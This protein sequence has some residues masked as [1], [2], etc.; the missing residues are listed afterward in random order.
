[1][2]DYGGVSRCLLGRDNRPNGGDRTNGEDRSGGGDTGEG[3]DDGDDGLGGVVGGVLGGVLG[4]SALVPKTSST[5]AA[6]AP[7]PEATGPKNPLRYAGAY[8]DTT[9]GEGNYYLQARNYNPG[10]GRFTATDPMASSRLAISS[11][12]YA[13][14]NPLV[15][16]DPTGTMVAPDP[17]GVGPSTTTEPDPGPSPEET[18]N[19]GPSPEE[20][21]KAQQIQS[22]SVLDVVLEAGGQ[23]LMEVLGINDLLKCLNG[24]LGACVSTVIGALPWGKIFKAKKIAEAIFRAG[25]AVITF[26]KEVKWARAIISGAEDAA[27][28]AKAAAAR[29]AKAA[30]QRAAAARAAAQRAA[31]AAA[32]K[33]AARAKAL[34]SKA[35]KTGGSR[36]DDA[37]R[38][39]PD[40]AGGNSSAPSC[41][42]SVPKRNSFVASTTILLADGTRKPIEKVQPGDTVVATDT[43]S[44][45]T[46]KRQV[47]HTIRTD[48]DKGIVDLTVRTKDGRHT[49]TTTEHHPF[50]STTNNH[51]VDAG[52][53]EPGDRLRTSGGGYAQ[54]GAVREGGERQLE[55][56][57]HVASLLRGEV[58][59]LRRPDGSHTNW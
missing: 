11:Y 35:K 10:T 33:A 43:T 16:T 1:M 56:L 12:V 57:E 20:L 29:A 5:T 21:A 23:I 46:E 40:N 6:A 44:G 26:F 32:E 54:I 55:N 27:K 34:R 9:T 50:W 4:S 24:D 48:D 31:K 17:G 42:V 13:D 22:K 15:H 37:P 47:T 58:P 52:D 8:Q 38:R 19:Q 28:A 25:K 59:H 36:T 30:A 53:L 7:G 2:A 18:K 3:D 49:I 41:P 45:R 51:W 39:G 14:N